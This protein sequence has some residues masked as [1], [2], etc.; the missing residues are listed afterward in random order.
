MLQIFPEQPAIKTD[1]HTCRQQLV[2]TLRSWK[3]GQHSWQGEQHG[4][5]A[6]A[7]IGQMC[8][9]TGTAQG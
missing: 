4:G 6:S 3:G 7:E 5:A 8:K 1:L 2:L 9:R